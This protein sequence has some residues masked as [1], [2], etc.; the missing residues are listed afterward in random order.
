M[1]I[2][3]LEKTRGF[4]KSG[5]WREILHYLR[6]VVYPIILDRFQPSFSWCI[7]QASTVRG[8]LRL[9]LLFI[10][11]IYRKTLYLMVKTMVSCRFS[12]K[13][14]QW[15]MENPWVFALRARFGRFIPEKIPGNERLQFWEKPHTEPRIKKGVWH[16]LD[17][18]KDNLFYLIIIMDHNGGY[19][20]CMLKVLFVWFSPGFF[21]YGGNP[22]G[23]TPHWDKLMISMS[24]HRWQKTTLK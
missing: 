4:L 11:K 13:P 10:G 20:N 9:V 1:F 2:V 3:I 16:Y 8:G 14:I 15:V 23:K 24:L 12:L 17:W 6:S 19:N 22:D 21:Y 5:W 7:S 18:L